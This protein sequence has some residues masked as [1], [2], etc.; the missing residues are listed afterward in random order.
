MKPRYADQVALVRA[1]QRYQRET[2]R[3][4]ADLEHDPSLRRWIAGLPPGNP[5]GNLLAALDQAAGETILRPQPAQRG[6][7]TVGTL[8]AMREEAPEPEP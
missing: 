4:R 7:V 6:T 1:Q 5:A 8:E 2:R 3:L